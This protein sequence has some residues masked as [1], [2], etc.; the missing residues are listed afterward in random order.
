MLAAGPAGFEVQSGGPTVVRQ[1]WTRWWRSDGA[2]VSE[3]PG[4][5]TR[6]TPLR[7]GPVRVRAGLRP[8]DGPDCAA[9][10]AGG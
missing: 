9:P 4:G 1:R 3:A 8:A 10:I 7:S 2:C 5:W 6:V